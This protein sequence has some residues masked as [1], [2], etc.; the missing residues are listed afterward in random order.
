MIGIF[1]TFKNSIQVLLKE[2]A[3][4]KN[5]KEPIEGSSF[6]ISLEPCFTE[7]KT[8]PCV[9]RLIKEKVKEV[10]IATKDPNPATHGKS[11]KKLEQAGIKTETGILE[12]QAKELN[13][14]FFKVM[15]TG[16]PYIYIKTASTL[17]GKI[18]TTEYHSKWITSDKARYHMHGL[19]AEVDAILVGTNTILQDNPYLSARREKTTFPTR[20]LIDRKE[21]LK[22]DLNVFNQ[23]GDVVIITTKK[24]YQRQNSK[25][26]V[27]VC[28]EKDNLVDL[29]DAFF[30]LAK[31]GINSVMVEG[32]ALVFA[33]LIKEHIIDEFHFYISPKLLG[34]GITF[35]EDEIK[36]KIDQALKLKFTETIM[37]GDDV[38]IKGRYADAQK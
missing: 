4:I 28:R 20:I 10:F 2:I 32:G 23:P 8:P 35:Y 19:R 5:A 9:D 34:E 14:H 38:L 12:K 6:Y 36:R 30:Q 24:D 13:K 27:I 25:V 16:L 18:A 26:K 7:G 17:D 1:L 3:A 21:K 33:N 15:Q 31:V 37:V 22:Y 29:K 11:I